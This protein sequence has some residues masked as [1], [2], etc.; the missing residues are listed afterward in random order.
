MVM[1]GVVLNIYKDGRLFVE[2]NA[3]LAAWQAETNRWVFSDAVF[4]KYNGEANPAMRR[5][6]SWSSEVSVPPENL[7]LE[8]LVPDGISSVEV[9]RRLRRLK[10]VGSDSTAE[11]TLLWVKLAAPLANPVMALIGAAIVLL[12][13][14][15][16]GFLSFGLAVGVGFFFWSVIIM[17]QE[18]G[19]AE[20]LPPF[21]AGLAPC[22]AFALVSLWGLR[23]ARAI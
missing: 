22:V 21:A 5:L 17:A 14:K 3:T 6:A 9:L 12:L 20:L 16:N 19:K 4:I 23:R 18:A 8:K 15:N 1:G 13:P 7:V 11:Q 2:V 10:S